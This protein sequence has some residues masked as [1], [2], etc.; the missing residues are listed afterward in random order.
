MGTSVRVITSVSEALEHPQSL[1]EMT[2]HLYERAPG[3]NSILWFCEREEVAREFV[4]ILVG[5]WL[6]APQKT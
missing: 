3:A 2:K 6:S 1:Q 4:L 5:V